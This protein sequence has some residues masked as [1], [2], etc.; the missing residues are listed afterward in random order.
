M[1]SELLLPSNPPRACKLPNHRSRRRADLGSGGDGSVAKG[2]DKLSAP[3]QQLNLSR[4]Q[5]KNLSHT[6]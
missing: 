1:V 3:R 4:T 6:H 5:Q 2:P